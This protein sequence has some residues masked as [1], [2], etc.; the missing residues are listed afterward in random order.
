[1]QLKI[2]QD[3]SSVV[4]SCLSLCNTQART[5]NLLQAIPCDDEGVTQACG[6]LRNETDRRVER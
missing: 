6:C 2:S 3:P 5:V 4:L 1:L